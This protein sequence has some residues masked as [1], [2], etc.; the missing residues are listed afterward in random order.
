M[1]C[2]IVKVIKSLP[3]QA[4]APFLA[5]VSIVPGDQNACGGRSMQ[6]VGGTLHA[7]ADYFF[8]R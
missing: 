6:A 7:T 1:T 3:G 4:T 2:D 8:T 5:G